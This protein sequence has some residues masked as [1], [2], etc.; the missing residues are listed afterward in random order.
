MRL[1]FLELLLLALQL[2][3]VVA[4]SLPHLLEFLVLL[5]N[6]FGVDQSLVLLLFGDL[7]EHL[8]VFLLVSQNLFVLN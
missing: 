3:I 1:P 4:L 7:I 2:H 5:L 6:L 8:L